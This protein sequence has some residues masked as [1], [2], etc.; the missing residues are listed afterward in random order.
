[1]IV[2]IQII[3][4]LVMIAGIAF[5]SN[6]ELMKKLIS[7]IA[8][9]RRVYYVAGFRVAFSVLLFFAASQCRHTAVV[10]LLGVVFLASGITAFAMS[11]EK[12]ASFMTWYQGRPYATLRVLAFVPV[13][14]GVVLLLSA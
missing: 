13:L 2:F 5:V 3:A 7:F 9:G 8:E 12:V 6:P 14:I 11:P 10:F 4:V 1:M